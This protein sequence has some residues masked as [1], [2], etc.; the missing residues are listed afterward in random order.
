MCGYNE[1]KRCL[2][3]LYSSY[4]VAKEASDKDDEVDADGD[5]I[6]D[7]KQIDA[8]ALVQRKVLL[9]MKSVDP[10]VV[11]E[12]WAGVWGGFMG[13]VAVLRVKF[14]QAITLGAAI[15]DTATKMA[16][17]TIKPSLIDATPPE[18]VGMCSNLICFGF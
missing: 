3:V 1:T 18:C 14:A 16:E 13:V 4:L 7:V 2:G 11:S 17:T 12:A 9:V 6:A 15:A 5:G 10:E 8:A